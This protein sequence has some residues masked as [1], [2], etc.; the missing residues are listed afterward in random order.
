MDHTL[1]QKAINYPNEYIK[2]F[3]NGKYPM[4]NK[5]QTKT[6]CDKCRIY[7]NYTNIKK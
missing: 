4:L 5:I 3:E 6:N 7:S 2:S 1:Q